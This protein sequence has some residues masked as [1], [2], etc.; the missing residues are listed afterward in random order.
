MIT[1]SNP[2]IPNDTDEIKRRLFEGIGIRSV[3]EIF[4]DIPKNI[5]R[6][7]NLS[8]PKAKSEVEV[9]KEVER[10]LS[11]NIS[12][13]DYLS[14]LGGGVWNHYV[15]SVVDAI[16]SRGEFL[17]S[18]T[19]YQPEISQGIL[20][21]L[22]EYQSMIAELIEL[23]VVNSSMYDWA[24]SLGEAARMANRVTHRSEI[25]VP[26]FI[27][28]N[29]LVTLKSYTNPLGMRIRE[30]SQSLHNG[31]IDLEDITK[32]I[33]SKTAA[34]YIENPS[35]LGFIVHHLHDLSEI[36]HESG[37]LFIVGVD[38]ISLG[39]LKPPGKYGADIVIGEG[40]PL[41]NYM[42]YGGPLLGI[43]ACR[44]NTP[45]V[46]Q[47]PGRIVG[48]TTTNDGKERGYCMVLQTREQH[49]R[50]EKATSNIC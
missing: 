15:P 37:S 42:N 13:R 40:Q 30:L 2:Y 39:I 10:I 6:I 5:P 7:E 43:F 41:G 32:N 24:S 9:R 22:F 50:R 49:I 38:P 46:R 11:K 45:L 18:Y 20:Q 23:D 3:E 4:A 16:A 34:I 28:P 36:A 47:L 27:S 31:Q 48:M 8:L 1:L 44:N 19:P 33:S 17:T 12:S 35:Y 21:S 14:F 25:F 26:H 29:R